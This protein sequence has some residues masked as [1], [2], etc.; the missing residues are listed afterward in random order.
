MVSAQD[1]L[2]SAEHF[3]TEQI[4]SRNP[5][6]LRYAVKFVRELILSK[7]LESNEILHLITPFQGYV[8][9]DRN[10]FLSAVSSFADSFEVIEEKQA[11]KELNSWVADQNY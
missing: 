8:A 9:T 5:F 4:Y 11:A 10:R 3:I 6:Q 1:N 2:N 7:K